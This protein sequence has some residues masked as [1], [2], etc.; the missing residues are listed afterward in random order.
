M[1]ILI[2][3]NL[4]IYYFTNRLMQRRISHNAL[5]KDNRTVLLARLLH[6]PI[7]VQNYVYFLK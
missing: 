7:G 3:Q 5:S 4:Q 2:K 1:F 6:C